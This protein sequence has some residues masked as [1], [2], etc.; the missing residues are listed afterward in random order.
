MKKTLLLTLDF[1]PRRGGV[2]TYLRELMRRLDPKQLIVLA[3]R[4]KNA[5]VFDREEPYTIYR[6]NLLSH[7]FWPR[8]F[9][10]YRTAKDIIQS[11]GIQRIIISHVLPMGYVCLLLKIPFIVI[12]HGYDVQLAKS[13]PWRRYWLKKILEKAERIVVNSEYT[14]RLVLE[15]GEW[16]DKVAIV[17]PCP[18]ELPSAQ[19]EN[20]MSAAPQLLS[21]G[22]LVERKGVDMV[23]QALPQVLKRFP[24]LRYYIV[25]EGGYHQNLQ[26]LVESLGLQNHVSFIH[27]ASSQDLADMYA[28]SDIFLMPARTVNEMDVEGFGIVFL[29]AALFGVPSIAGDSGGQPEAVIHGKTGLIVNPRNPSAVAEAI[30]SLLENTQL[31]RRLG[32]QARERVQSEFTWDKQ[33]A[34][35]VPYLD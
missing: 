20:D 19:N 26:H 14:Q 8:W 11:E 6:A 31:R 5:F 13:T 34:K 24:D 10:A 4:E 9:S 32:A 2:A 17:Y 30:I 33:I 35:I 7:Y 22:R 23:L 1:P 25:G 21:V 16:K 18:Q 28:R 3:Q 12:L 29:E 15:E 27:A